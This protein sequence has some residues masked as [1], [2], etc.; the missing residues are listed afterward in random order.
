MIEKTEGPEDR[1]PDLVDDRVSARSRRGPAR[2]RS[3]EGKLHLGD[4]VRVARQVLEVFQQ[5]RTHS[6]L[7]VLKNKLFRFGFFPKKR[8]DNCICIRLAI[9]LFRVFVNWKF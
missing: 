5:H 4:L 6:D 1:G 2:G 8:L 3:G 7:Q 9:Q